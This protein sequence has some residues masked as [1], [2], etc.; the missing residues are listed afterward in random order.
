VEKGEAAAGIRNKVDSMAQ[1]WEKSAS[2][3]TSTSF[4]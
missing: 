3:E 1:T 4:F 2:I